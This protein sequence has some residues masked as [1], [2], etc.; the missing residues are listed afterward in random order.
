MHPKLL[1]TSGR[2]E[3]NTTFLMPGCPS[4]AVLPPLRPSPECRGFTRLASG[5]IIIRFKVYMG[6]GFKGAFRSQGSAFR[7]SWG[8]QNPF[9]HFEQCSEKWQNPLPL[10][11]SGSRGGGGFSRGSRVIACRASA[12]RSL[13]K[14]GS[15]QGVRMNPLNPKPSKP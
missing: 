1:W 14:V 10:L 7:R 4:R 12:A 9:G 15:D 3:L 5:F 8:L 11:R 13:Q 2:I 6:L